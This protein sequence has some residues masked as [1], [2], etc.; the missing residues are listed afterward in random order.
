ML[1]G[2]GDGLGEEVSGELVAAVGKADRQLM[3]R[4]S[5]ALGGAARAGTRLARGGDRYSNSSS[6]SSTNFLVQ[7]E[8]GRM[9]RNAD[10]RRSLVTAHRLGAGRHEAVERATDRFSQSGDADE[11]GVEVSSAS[12]AGASSS[13]LILAPWDLLCERRVDGRTSAV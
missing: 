13:G 7:M 4:P 1:V 9:R 12:P 3:C 2:I 11:G 8:L 5:V 6:P 10:T